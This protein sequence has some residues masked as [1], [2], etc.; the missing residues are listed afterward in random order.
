LARFS[1]ITED[2]IGTLEVLAQRVGGHQMKAAIIAVALRGIL[3][4]CLEAAAA[5]ENRGWAPTGMETRGYAIS[6]EKALAELQ[7]LLDALP[8][9]AE[10]DA[11]R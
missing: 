2:D 6:R 11:A 9:T 3:G 1:L 7:S 10:R 5:D 4:L 8:M